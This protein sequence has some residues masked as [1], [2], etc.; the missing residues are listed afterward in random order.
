MTIKDSTELAQMFEQAEL[1]FVP[2]F[3]KMSP[4]I[5]AWYQKKRRDLPWRK[6]WHQFKDPYSVWVSEI[7][8]QQTTIAAVLP[9]Y[10]EFMK[11]YPDLAAL[12]AADEEE[13]R[14]TVRGLGYYRRFSFLYKAAGQLMARSKRREPD[15]PK[16]F[17]EWKEVAGVGDYT[18]A[19]VSSIAFGCPEVVVDGNVE[20]VFCR[21]LDMRVPT[22]VKGLKPLI[23]NIGNAM[24]SKKHPGDFN[25]GLM[26]LGQTICTPSSPRCGEC[27]IK[28]WCKAYAHDSTMLAP[29]PKIK[30]KKVD[31]KLRL[32]ICV[33]GGSI[34]LVKRPVKAKFLKETYGFATEIQTG[35][36][37]LLDGAS[38]PFVA[39]Q[40]KQLGEI[41]HSITNHRLNVEVCQ[42]FLKSYHKKHA[43][44]W[45]RPDEVE[46]QLISNLDRKAWLLFQ[47]T[48]TGPD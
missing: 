7:M 12:A 37:F 29:A 27:P 32:S 41:K 38:S 8:L 40:S 5:L 43:I 16:S 22:N 46:S 4:K 11:R 3:K 14:Q 10:E 47:K 48:S 42:L 26:E 23:R 9:K 30:P 17:L 1:T 35:Q 19:A 18:A 28:S 34:G 15:W 2:A 36:T 24:I 39:R 25:Q 44:K 31:L 21:L 20:R 6:L 13:V 45:V 33:K